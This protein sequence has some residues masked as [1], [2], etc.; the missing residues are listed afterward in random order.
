MTDDVLKDAA[1]ELKES[2]RVNFETVNFP[3]GCI[4]VDVE[5]SKHHTRSRIALYIRIL[6]LWEHSRDSLTQ[7]EKKQAIQ[8]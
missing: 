3:N 8:L 5:R 4:N 1:K 2:H 7:E 6:S